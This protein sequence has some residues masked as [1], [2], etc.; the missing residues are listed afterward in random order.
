VDVRL[1]VTNFLHKLQ[2]TLQIRQFWQFYWFDSTKLKVKTRQ[3]VSMHLLINNCK[4]PKK[5]FSAPR[6]RPKANLLR[7]W[8]NLFDGLDQSELHPIAPFVHQ[9]D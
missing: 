5:I 9:A 3:N 7:F 8:L 4:N 6:C 2:K 1:A